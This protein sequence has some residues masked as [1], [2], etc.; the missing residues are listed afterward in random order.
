MYNTCIMFTV[1]DDPC[2]P[3]PCRFGTCSSL[4]EPNALGVQ[5]ECT[6]YGSFCGTRCETRCSFGT[7]PWN[8]CNSNSLSLVLAE[9]FDD[10]ISKSAHHIGKFRPPLPHNLVLMQNDKT[11]FT[12]FCPIEIST[13]K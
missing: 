4:H 2:I 7:G 5:F 8:M 10:A 3:N 13:N 6:C 9:T 11:I 12:S 1:A